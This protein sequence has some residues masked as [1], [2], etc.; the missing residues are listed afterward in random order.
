[1]INRVEFGNLN[2]GE[3]TPILIKEKIGADG[4]P[5]VRIYQRKDINSIKNLTGRIKTTIKYGV[6][7]FFIEH[8]KFQPLL[9]KIGFT[10][11]NQLKTDEIE[12]PSNLLQSIKFGARI[13]S[14]EVE[15]EKK[16]KEILGNNGF[17]G[18]YNYNFYKGNYK[19]EDFL[20][21]LTNFAELSGK[22][23][24]DDHQ[25]IA[26][27]KIGAIGPYILKLD[28]MKKCKEKIEQ[29]KN[30]LSQYFKTQ[31]NLLAA[32]SGLKDAELSTN[33]SSAK[34]SNY[35][36]DLHSEIDGKLTEIENK[37]F[38]SSND[39]KNEDI[40]NHLLSSLNTRLAFGNEEPSNG[41]ETRAAIDILFST[42]WWISEERRLESLDKVREF[43][44]DFK[45]RLPE[46]IR[47]RIFAGTGV[48]GF[49]DPHLGY[50]TNPRR[51]VSNPYSGVEDD[52]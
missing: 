50:S 28:E 24:A 34:I 43:W 25:L 30:N 37:M 27:I 20:N 18:E 31:N 15:N 5:S 49:A 23:S 47:E 42:S 39:P 2:R 13:G 8:K 10:K 6:E 35:L 14:V 29:I 48:E 52:S 45:D 21:D 4:E 22:Q 32:Q 11:I 36:D 19:T 38:E 51:P 12:N 3:N 33:N 16:L 46:A 7:D 41:E 17:D 9:E 44:N 1:M 40:K 26:L